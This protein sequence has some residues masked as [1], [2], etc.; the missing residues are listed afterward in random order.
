MKNPQE[1]INN[2]SPTDALSI[3]KT[4]AANDEQLANRIAKIALDRLSQVDPEE[5]AVVV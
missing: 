3:L 5:V 4:L 2:L 1:I